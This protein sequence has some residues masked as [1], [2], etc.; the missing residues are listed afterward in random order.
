MPPPR[1]LGGPRREG[2]RV[3]SA[4]PLAAAVLMTTAVA[5]LVT[6]SLEGG[7]G[8]GGGAS[9]AAAPPGRSFVQRIL[10]GGQRVTADGYGGGD[11]GPGRPGCRAD[12]TPGAAAG[13]AA[14]AA[15]AAYVPPT[16]A[17]GHLLA[18]G[19]SPWDE[20]RLDVAYDPQSQDLRQLLQ[21]ADGGGGNDGGGGDA[22]AWRA[23][24][25]AAPDAAGAAVYDGP[26]FRHMVADEGC[27]VF[28]L[29]TYHDYAGMGHRF[30]NLV[31]G[32]VA[33]LTLDATLLY[34]P[35]DYRSK[36]HGDY[37]GLDGFLGMGAGEW[38]EATAR[39]RWPNLTLIDLPR[40]DNYAPLARGGMFSPNSR[41]ALWHEKRA[42]LNRKCHLM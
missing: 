31:M 24:R 30:S 9:A 28:I 22:A 19:P 3:A 39:A 12:D 16:T 8:A 38:S 7:D 23:L 10:N 11:S 37:A 36:P 27:P 21:P 26:L 4:V 14:A 41:V 35:M 42:A 5:V 18:T 29:P 15:V 20:L 32:L 1:G 25:G 33:A 40:L 6:R 34:A 13:N 17:D 2:S